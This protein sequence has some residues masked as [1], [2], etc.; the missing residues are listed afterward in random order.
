MLFYTLKA[1]H[2]AFIY[3]WSSA[4]ATG[5]YDVIMWYYKKKDFVTLQALLGFSLF[6]I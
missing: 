4:K 2:L 1:A 6:I 3:S 5:D